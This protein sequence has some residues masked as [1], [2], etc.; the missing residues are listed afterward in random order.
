[1]DKQKILYDGSRAEDDAIIQHGQHR[2]HV[3][4]YVHGT[5][6]VLFEQDNKVILPGSAFTA[7]K[8]FKDLSIPVKTPTYNA[9]LGLDNIVFNHPY[10]R[11]CR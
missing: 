8:H 10:R 9:A 7:T 6:K 4:A 1:M 5:D 11:S 2:G 3:I